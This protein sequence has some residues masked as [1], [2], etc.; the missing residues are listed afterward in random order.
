MVNWEPFSVDTDEVLS[1]SP[2]NTVGAVLITKL[3]SAVA[4]L[5]FN[6]VTDSVSCLM[7][8]AVQV[9]CVDMGTRGLVSLCLACTP[10]KCRR[11][12]VAVSTL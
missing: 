7:A 2:C 10:R 12:S 1:R 3:L 9:S 5:S 11:L 6:G 4:K 8:S